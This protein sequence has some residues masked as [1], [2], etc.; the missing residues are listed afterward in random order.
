MPWNL[1]KSCP[2]ISMAAAASRSVFSFRGSAWS[3]GA[4]PVAAA[5]LTASAGAT[6]SSSG[7][8]RRGDGSSNGSL[9]E[10]LIG[11]RRLILDS[12]SNYTIIKPKIW[13]R[14]HKANKIHRKTT[15][16]PYHGDSYCDITLCLAT[17]S[18]W[19]RP[20]GHAAAYSW[21][22][23]QKEDFSFHSPK[24]CRHWYH[25]LG[26]WAQ[27][28]RAAKHKNLLSMKSLPW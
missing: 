20:Q 3:G 24:W 18:L 9:G 21:G 4:A 16:Q 2:K 26:T 17:S 14:F 15:C 19:N 6:G 10:L 25:P 22:L 1:T 13:G 27:F 11:D 12:P 28:H 7:S 23:K 5:S 8:S